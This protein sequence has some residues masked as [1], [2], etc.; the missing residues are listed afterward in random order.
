LL[1]RNLW[2]LSHGPVANR[3]QKQRKQ[4]QEFVHTGR[5]ADSERNGQQRWVA[6]T[7]VKA[8]ER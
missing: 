7:N 6:E 4:A 5:Q 2:R 1:S 8:V 3:A